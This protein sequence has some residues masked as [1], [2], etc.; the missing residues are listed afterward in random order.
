MPK[1]RTEKYAI[2]RCCERFGLL[3]P[4][5]KKEWDENSV[6]EQA[7]LLVFDYIRQNEEV[8]QKWQPPL[9]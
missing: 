4:Y 8:E 6:I 7:D 9:G 2:W 1:W 5:V 3:P